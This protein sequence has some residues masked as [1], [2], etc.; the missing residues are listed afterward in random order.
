MLAI[1]KTATNIVKHAARA[2]SPKAPTLCLV[3][4]LVAIAGGCVLACVRTVDVVTDH[5]RMQMRLDDIADLKEE[6]E[7]IHEMMT[8]E[9]REFVIRSVKRYLAPAGLVLGGGALVVAGH[10]VQARRL[11]L[12]ST[13][14][15]SLLV[16]FEA[17]RERVR[18]AE[19]D[20]KD[21][22]YL[23]GTEEMPVE[24]TETG[25][26]GKTKTK[27]K[28]AVTLRTDSQSLYN[29]CWDEFSSSEWTNDYLYNFDFLK[30]CER[31]ANQK[32]IAQ[33]YLFLDEVYDMLGFR[34]DDGI[35]AGAKLVGWIR[36]DVHSNSDRVS[37]G[38]YDPFER[39]K[40]FANLERP[41]DAG[42]WLNFNCDGVIVDKL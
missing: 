41:H 14:Y 33:G 24:V 23:Y 22:G 20:D 8:D 6:P 2:I 21:M 35:S 30:M 39:A 29:R 12:M 32:L 31:V 36:S 7:T 13:A 25:K 26:D 37:F 4:G 16:S 17:Y 9:K 28:K 5:D 27:T 19:G 1:V 11:A 34:M 3:G 40:T 42:Y 18:D 38:I 10:T 15:N